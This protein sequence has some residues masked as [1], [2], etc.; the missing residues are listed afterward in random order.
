VE[1][2]KIKL[3]RPVE[4]GGEIVAQLELRPPKGKDLRAIVVSR[5]VDL[6]FGEV[7][8]L[9]GKLA[10]KPPELMDSLEAADVGKVLT[11]VV[12]FLSSMSDKD[13]STS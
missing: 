8:D 7:L 3:E 6:S 11:A 1:S 9:G 2:K 4:F 12:D 10:G 5:I 13:S